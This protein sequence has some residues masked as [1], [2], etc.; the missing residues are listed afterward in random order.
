MGCP[1]QYSHLR[2]SLVQGELRRYWSPIVTA[3]SGEQRSALAS[4]NLYVGIGGGYRELTFKQDG[5]FPDDIS[6]VPFDASFE[7]KAATWIG[8]LTVGG[9]VRAHGSQFIS[10]QASYQFG[11]APGRGDFIGFRAI[12]V[13][14]LR[15]SIG[16][17]WILGLH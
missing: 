3:G 13:S 15:A 9:L 2:T 12:D 14:G 6:G 4:A 7:G 11:S 17:G 16:F 5:T 10:A 8:S 1:I